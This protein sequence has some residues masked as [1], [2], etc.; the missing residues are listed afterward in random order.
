MLL[1][2]HAVSMLATILITCPR[3]ERTRSS[4]FRTKETE[5]ED[6]RNASG[7]ANLGIGSSFNYRDLCFGAASEVMERPVANFPGSFTASDKHIVERAPPNLRITPGS[8]IMRPVAVRAR[9]VCIDC[10]FE[11]RLGSS[12]QYE[13]IWLQRFVVEVNKLCLF[14]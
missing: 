1:E 9:R 14:H 7:K 4:L 2:W 6:V 10:D 13:N 12:E 8:N 11:S 5:D 3:G